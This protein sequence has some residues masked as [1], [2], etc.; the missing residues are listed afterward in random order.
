MRWPFLFLLIKESQ[1]DKIFLVKIVKE[2][3]FLETL[4]YYE[5]K[6]MFCKK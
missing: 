2:L 3:F 6:N 1:N 5:F 4:I